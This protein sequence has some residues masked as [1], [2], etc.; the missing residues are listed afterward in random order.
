RGLNID[1]PVRDVVL[2]EEPFG[3]AAV[4]APWGGVNDEL[5]RLVDSSKPAPD[6][7][8]GASALSLSSSD[9]FRRTPQREPPKPPSVRVTRWHGMRT[10]TGF[11]AQARATARCARGCPIPDAI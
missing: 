2:R 4:R 5:H 8:S 1:F 10:A 6:A 3:F 11:A 7:G 9:F